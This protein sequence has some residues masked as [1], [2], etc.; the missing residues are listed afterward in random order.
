LLLDLVACSLFAPGLL[1]LLVPWS[2]LQGE[3]SPLIAGARLCRTSPG[4]HRALSPRRQSLALTSNHRACALERFFSKEFSNN[5]DIS[6]NSQFEQQFGGI[7]ATHRVLAR[8][9]SS[10]LFGALQVYFNY[11]NQLS[12][13]PTCILGLS[14]LQM[15]LSLANHHV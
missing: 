3:V 5:K 13:L 12:L 15:T 7:K 6:F 2:L 14:S 8:C 9:F 10:P 1:L 4:S 11:C